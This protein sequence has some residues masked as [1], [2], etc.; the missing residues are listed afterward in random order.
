MDEQIVRHVEDA[1]CAVDNRHR[2][3]VGAG[4]LLVDSTWEGDCSCLAADRRAFLATACV[5]QA[6]LLRVRDEPAALQE[7]LQRAAATSGAD[8]TRRRLAKVF[9]GCDTK[10]TSA[11]GRLGG[12]RENT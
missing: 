9:T 10:A 4:V 11:A 6:E 1:A 2:D 8:A 7:H 5:R 12:F 3:G